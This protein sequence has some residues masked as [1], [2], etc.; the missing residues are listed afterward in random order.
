MTD[1]SEFDEARLKHLDMLQSV[2]GRLGTNGFV[3]KGWAI[4]VAGAFFG[5]AVS[6][7]DWGLAAA[8][9]I[10]TVLFWFLDAYFLRA[11]RLF[12]SLFARVR[13][14]TRTEA[15]FMDATGAEFVASLGDAERQVAS[16][17]STAWRPT[18]R[19]L[20]GGIVTA[21]IV[22]ALIVAGLDD[23][24]SDHSWHRHE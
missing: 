24:S 4:T 17:R 15:F 18:L 3:I 10:P 2:I 1:Y 14:A 5:F 21:A 9:V 12:R 13:S 6:E 7:R 16:L 8:S 23:P 19:L 22:V 20:Y 11:E